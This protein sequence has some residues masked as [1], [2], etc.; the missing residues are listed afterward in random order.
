MSQYILFHVE[1]G[2]GKNVMATAVAAAISKNHPE[3][4]L[5]VVSS[6]P[7]VW[8]NNPDI[9]R[10]YPMGLALYFY[11]DYIKDKDTLIFKSEP[12]HHQ[13]FINKKRSLPDI[14]CEQLGV[15]YKN[16]ET[17][18]ILTLSEKDKMK[19]R[20]K[21]AN[22]PVLALQTNGGGCQDYPISWVRD[23]P[24]ENLTK[25]I[26]GFQQEYKIIHIR[27]KDQPSIDGVDYMETDNIRDLFCLIDYSSKRLLIDSF[28]QHVAKALFKPSVVLW[29]LDNVKTLGYPSF[30]KNIIS[31][32]KKRKTHLTDSYLADYPID[33]SNLHENPF[34]TNFIFD[35]KVIKEAV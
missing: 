28:A 33:G 16:E 21:E 9:Y 19:T 29:P 8:I 32:A 25:L 22:K 35:T 12:Y 7:A 20:L 2:I 30:H 10:F 31:T 26:E 11:E 18:I 5:I 15:N 13:D 17:K 27:K 23:V 34:D 3:R 1:G 4:K 24:L 6:W 14:W